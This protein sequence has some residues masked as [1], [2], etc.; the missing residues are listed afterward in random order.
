[1]YVFFLLVLSFALFHASTRSNPNQYKQAGDRVRA[2]AEFASFV[3]LCFYVF[4]EVNQIARYHMNFT[5]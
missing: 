1:M 3:L 2:V 5:Q 4:E